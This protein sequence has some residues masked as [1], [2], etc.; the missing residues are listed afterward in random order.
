MGRI[1]IA[2]TS[3]A[4]GCA[5]AARPQP[6]PPAPVVAAAAPVALLGVLGVT[7]D[8]PADAPRAAGLT[9]ELRAQVTA[10]FVLTTAAGADRP[11]AELTQLA[12]CPT[13][14]AACMASIGAD[15]RVAYLIYGHLDPDHA[16][17][18]LALLDVGAHFNRRVATGTSA[19]AA[20]GLLVAGLGAGPCAP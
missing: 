2:C 12:T 9:L 3:V 5:P 18:H 19:R 20:Y 14:S 13:E 16:Q 15:L 4:L 10:P 6:R 1:S 17:L 8:D 7:A 11:L